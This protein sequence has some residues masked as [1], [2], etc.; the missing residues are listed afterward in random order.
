MTSFQDLGL[1][2]E[3]LR[4]LDEEDI[5]RPTALQAAVIPVL[6]RGGN[7]V[8]RAST[9]S[10]KTLAY[11]LGI[12]DR[13]TPRETGEDDPAGARV[14]ILVPTGGAAERAALA[15]FPYAQATELSLTVPGGTWATPT[16][17]AEVI[18]ATPAVFLGA[19]RES[20]VKLTGLEAVVV[21]GAAAIQELGGWDAIDTLLDS[22][23][24]DAQRILLSS[25]LTGEI[26]SLAER[27]VRRAL[28]YPSEPAVSGDQS[29]SPEGAI[30]Y[31]L[32]PERDKPDMLARLLAQPREGNTPPILYCRTDE[33]AAGVAEALTVRGFL[34]GGS[35]DPDADIALVAVGTS[36]EEL[37]EETGEE[38]GRSISYDVPADEEM[39]RARHDGDPLA[40]VLLEP[41]EL[42][43][44][45][46]L[47]KQTRL[48]TTAIPVP[49]GGDGIASELAPFRNEIRRALREEDLGA[50]MLV[51]EPLFEEFDAIEIA[52][53]ASALLRH[54]RPPSPAA[55]PAVAPQ[56][57]T[58]TGP[59]PATWARLYV[60][61][62]DRDG[63][64]PGDLVGAITGEAN[65]PGSQIGKIDIRDTFS[66][67]EIQAEAAEAVIRAVN[68]TTIK[69][70][71]VR[72][73]YDRAADRGRRAGAREGG[74]VR[75]RL[76]EGAPPRRQPRERE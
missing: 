31:V 46:E 13:L 65:V 4:T 69:G 2:D 26:E 48:E 41:G 50:Q 52:A 71:S 43:H 51:L 39:L 25:V 56:R 72:V 66:I 3:L 54:R 44:L 17:G 6:R 18:V 34:I 10:G 45:R 60:G 42:P 23:P 35:G 64:R 8:A 32:V 11:A 47:A 27:R 73:D 68:G 5:E 59:P 53:A 7:L 38:P 14:L 22:I 49:A 57:Q 1:R 9:G 75:R 63:V 67:V 62:G 15:L 58:E 21:D 61:V 28:R 29:A 20:A 40:V 12:L 16:A 33:R 74:G 55:A 76:K 19:V 70:R 37:T 30:G 36:R 24:R